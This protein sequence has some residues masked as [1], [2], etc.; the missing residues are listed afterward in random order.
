MANYETSALTAYV[1]VNKDV[2]IKNIVLGLAKGDSIR[3]FRKQF[4]IKKTERLNY[5]NVEP[6]IQD[7][8]G[9]SFN[10]AGSTSF[11]ERDIT[12]A[13]MKAQDNFC[14]DL[15]RGKFA[16]YLVKTAANKDASDMPFEQEILDEVVEGINEKLEKL[17]WQGATSGNSGTDLID[18]FLTQALNQDS[19]S[20]IMVTGSSATSM[21][22]RVQAMIMAIPEDWLDKAVIFLSPAN[23]RKLLFELV[24]KNLYHYPV[25]AEIEDRDVIFPGSE[26]R[27]HKTIG[28]KGSDYIVCSAWENLVYGT[29]LENDNEKIRF[30]YDDN[31][32][33]FKYS[34]HWVSGVKSL[35]PDAVM[36]GD[37]SA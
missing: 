12:V 21:Y 18:G 35:F 17:V 8:A 9:C 32:E 11:S 20:T 10:A 27:I 22:A 19:A 26:V 1:E 14:D 31:S 6:T 2:L 36:V 15:L 29:D 4:G 7:G 23:Y 24:E 25:G 37:F 16:E 13:E 3:N 5:L 28:L 34:I 33:L 30:W